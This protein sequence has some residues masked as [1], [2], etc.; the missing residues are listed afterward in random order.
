MAARVPPG[1]T[2]LARRAGAA[3]LVDI[4]MLA[5]EAG[6]HPDLVRRFVQLGL[7]EPQMGP[8]FVARFPPDAAA[9]LA[10]AA[11]LRRDLALNYAGAI[12][13]AELLARIDQLE[14]RLSRYEPPNRLR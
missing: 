12:L 13:A 11:R 8:D 5:R 9:R 4:A 1:R 6:L 14:E 7:L 10:R 2:R 3:P